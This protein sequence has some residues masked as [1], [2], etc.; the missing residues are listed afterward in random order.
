MP[1]GGQ[2][3][4]GDAQ[5]SIFF[6]DVHKL[7]IGR[8]ETAERWHQTMNTFH[9]FTHI[10]HCHNSVCDYRQ[11]TNMLIAKMLAKNINNIKM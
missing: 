1:F 10:V 8:L 11:P 9:Q 6:A 7:L 5:V 2:T 4:A 3:L